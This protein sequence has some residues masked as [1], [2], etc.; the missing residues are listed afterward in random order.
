MSIT[1]QKQTHRYIENKLVTA[2]T[3]EER[4][5]GTGKM[6]GRVLRST[7]SYILVNSNII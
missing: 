7:N 3:T 1:K 2:V 4:E 5:E 6:K